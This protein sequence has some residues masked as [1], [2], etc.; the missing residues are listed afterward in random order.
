MIIANIFN[1]LKTMWDVCPML[2]VVACI[3][4]ALSGTGGPAGKWG[5]GIAAV[6]FFIAALCS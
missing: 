4:L 3:V 5:F 1:S 6:V 2:A